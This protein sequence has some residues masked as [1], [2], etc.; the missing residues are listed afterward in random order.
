MALLGE[1]AVNL[2]ARTKSFIKGMKQAEK[3]TKKFG[4]EVKLA[5][6]AMTAL[7]TAFAGYG[8]VLSVNFIKNTVA[9]TAA[10]VR[11]AESLGLTIAQLQGYQQA[12]NRLNVSTEIM[13]DA[14]RELSRRS[15]E[16]TTGT[17]SMADALEMLQ[18]DANQFVKLDLDTQFERITK[19]LAGLDNI[20]MRNFLTDE[21]FGGASDEITGLTD[22]I[23]QLQGELEQ[24]GMTAVEGEGFK[25][26][27][28]S[29]K[30]L[31]SIINR[32]GKQFLIDIT[33]SA[34][35]ALEMLERAAPTFTQRQATQQ[36]LSQQPGLVGTSF[37][38]MPTGV[39]NAMD[40]M[41]RHMNQAQ[42]RTRQ[43]AQMRDRLLQRE[44]ERRHQEMMKAVKGNGDARGDI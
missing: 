22:D 21:I 6:R 1:L 40:A 30:R 4:Q 29:I 27:D 33:P 38:M 5:D 17:G 7:S 39:F 14:L 24:L 36:T 2:V 11:F 15:A 12:A 32:V 18:I 35:K 20:Q 31:E 25:R 9:S 44:E 42:E 8:A 43:Q 16:A 23:N 41:A 13:N 19:A 3:T 10:N 28:E 26:F 37:E 34:V